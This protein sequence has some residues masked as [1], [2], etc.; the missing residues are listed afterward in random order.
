MRQIY[1]I[2]QNGNAHIIDKRNKTNKQENITTRFP[3]FSFSDLFR[4]YH[5]SLFCLFWIVIFDIQSCWLIEY[6]SMFIRAYQVVFKW[7]LRHNYLTS[8]FRIQIPR[9]NLLNWN[10]QLR[11]H[12]CIINT[13]EKLFTTSHEGESP[14]QILDTLGNFIYYM[15]SVWEVLYAFKYT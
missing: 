1:Y 9:L 13:I 6:P 8:V 10:L 5:H 2:P 15:F 7:Y 14:H 12:T 4:E 3:E 11:A